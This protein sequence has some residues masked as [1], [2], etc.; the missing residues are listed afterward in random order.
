MPI[1]V[2]PELRAAPSVP[3]VGSIETRQPGT[4]ATAAHR[5]A[6]AMGRHCGAFAIRAREGGV[7]RCDA[8]HASAPRH[9]DRFVSTDPVWLDLHGRLAV[10]QLAEYLMLARLEIGRDSRV[11]ALATV[12]LRT[13]DCEPLPRRLSDDLDAL[14][15]H[16]VTVEGETLDAE[17]ADEPPISKANG[18]LRASAR[19]ALALLGPRRSQALAREAYT[20][21]AREFGQFAAAR[22]CATLY[23]GVGVPRFNAEETRAVLKSRGVYAPSVRTLRGLQIGVP[24]AFQPEGYWRI[25]ELPEGVQPAAYVDRLHDPRGTYSFLIFAENS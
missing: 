24:Y 19:E 9:G 5:A 23:P 21:L 15:V 12:A 3:L 22:V 20:Y 14:T 25:D 16:G 17:P 8:V 7:L 1:T 10:V 4:V 2:S 18:R 13:D 6:L 11:P